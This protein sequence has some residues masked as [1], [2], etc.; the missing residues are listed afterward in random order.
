MQ[1]QVPKLDKLAMEQSSANK[2]TKVVKRQTVVAL[3][4]APLTG[5]QSCD[6]D[7]NFRLDVATQY[8]ISLIHL[9]HMYLRPAP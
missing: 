1:N 8:S 2:V 3:D 4:T 6:A 7:N 5:D 9:L